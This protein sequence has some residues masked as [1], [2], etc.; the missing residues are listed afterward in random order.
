M[1]LLALLM[2]CQQA[3]GQEAS[4]EKGG[5]G[6]RVTSSSGVRLSGVARVRQR[7]ATIS[8]YAGAPPVQY[9]P[10]LVDA[11]GL[12]VTEAGVTSGTGPLF[13]FDRLAAYRYDRL[14]RRLDDLEALVRAADPSAP[15]VVAWPA[16]PAEEP[17]AA[18]PSDSIAASPALPVLPTPPVRSPAPLLE[19][20]RAAS[21]MVEV[22]TRQLLDTGLFR[23]LGVLF[24]SGQ[25]TLLPAATTILDA[26]GTALVQYP[27]L[28][29]EVAGHTDAVGTA[30][31]NQRL[32]EARAAAVRSYLIEQFGLDPARITAQG[33]G[34]AS[35]IAENDTPTGR[36][37]NRRVEFRV[38]NEAAVV[39]V[40]AAV[41][42]ADADLREVIREELERWRTRP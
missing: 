23:A 32:S 15:T 42:D 37:L 7:I 34:E 17:P 41:P 33:Y 6:G 38:R 25:H 13:T 4:P 10:V 5:A 3:Q 18:V 40:P 24:A 20:P 2:P 28:Q 8:A 27:A 29:V 12:P 14:L 39:P 31:S 19:L 9:V 36:A 35:P 21:P 26:V 22:V 11:G 1:G 16:R 30:A